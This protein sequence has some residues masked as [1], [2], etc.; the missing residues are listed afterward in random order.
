MLLHEVCTRGT[1]PATDLTKVQFNQISA[2]TALL[3]IP[4]GTSIIGLLII[5]GVFNLLLEL[6][7]FKDLEADETG[8]ELFLTLPLMLEGKAR[9]RD[10]LLGL[11]GNVNTWVT[12]AVHHPA[13]L[14]NC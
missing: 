7:L 1:I 12:G 9:A 14:A 6:K 8:A 3:G 5:V 2:R 11:K 4:D 13:W 10:Y